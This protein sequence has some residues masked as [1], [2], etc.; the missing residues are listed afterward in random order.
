MY[1]YEISEK[2]RRILSDYIDKSVRGR[3]NAIRAHGTVRERKMPKLS[4]V[5]CDFCS[6]RID[7]M[8]SLIS[9]LIALSQILSHMDKRYQYICNRLSVSISSLQKQAKYLG[10]VRSAIE[11]DDPD[12]AQLKAVKLC[13]LGV[14]RRLDYL[15]EDILVENIKMTPVNAYLNIT[16][17]TFRSALE[18]EF[19][20]KEE[21]YDKEKVYAF[22]DKI[23]AV[24]KEAGREN[25]HEEELKKLT[26]RDDKKHDEA[27]KRKMEALKK[28]KDDADYALGTFIGAFQS[29]MSQIKTNKKI[30]LYNDVIRDRINQYG[31]DC[32]VVL[33]A[34]KSKSGLVYRYM[35]DD[36]GMSTSF[37]NANIFLDKEEAQNA[38]EQYLQENKYHAAE[39]VPFFPD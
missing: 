23:L 1:N 22:A 17:Q 15:E 2:N 20:T 13:I 36:G 39:A 14:D 26:V 32:F 5:L 25:E 18:S 7:A 34:Y 31:R 12:D 28:G 37:R 35:K 6:E 24:V 11:W 8:Y 10:C 21:L 38:T 29:G 27:E 30:H 4:K 16:G 3:K 19:P 9:C 33:I